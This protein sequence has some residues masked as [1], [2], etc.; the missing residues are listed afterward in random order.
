MDEETLQKTVKGLSAKQGF[1]DTIIVHCNMNSMLM[2]CHTTKR[3]ALKFLV[4]SDR[5]G[6]NVFG[7][8]RL[9]KQ[10]CRKRMARCGAC[11]GTFCLPCLREADIEY[12]DAKA[13]LD[14]PLCSVVTKAYCVCRLVHWPHV[15]DENFL[16]EF[17]L[18]HSK[19][20]RGDDGAKCWECSA[21]ANKFCSCVLGAVYCS[22]VSR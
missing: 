2:D 8:C 12:E 4:E 11:A 16:C 3:T 5:T 18:R 13:V 22:T 9:C 6:H 20:A 1:K 14:C 19:A 21:P 7:T 15:L 10:V 17:Q